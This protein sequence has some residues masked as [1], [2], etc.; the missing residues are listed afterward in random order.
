MSL[1]G[2]S[3]LTVCFRLYLFLSVCSLSLSHFPWFETANLNKD[4]QVKFHL[5]FFLCLSSA[6]AI[7]KDRY[8]TRGT[9]RHPRHIGR[10]FRLSRHTSVS[11]RHGSVCI[12]VCECGR[13]GCQA[14]SAAQGKFRGGGM[15]RKKI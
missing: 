4:G 8:P 5:H 1:C 2:V 9:Q 12:C 10:T 14:V 3:S 15:I 13:R 7:G 11:S 6:G